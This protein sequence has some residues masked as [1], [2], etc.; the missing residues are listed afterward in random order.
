MYVWVGGRLGGRGYVCV[1]VCVCAV[2]PVDGTT[3]LAA[4]LPLVTCS[5]ALARRG[6]VELG[7]VYDPC[8]SELFAARRGRGA[9]LNGQRIGGGGGG[10]GPPSASLPAKPGRVP[11]QGA[12]AAAGSGDGIEASAAPRKPA[13]ALRDVVFCVGFPP[14]PKAFAQQVALLGGLGPKVRG[15]RSLASCALAC[16]WVGAG[17]LGAYVARDV[18]AWDFA[19]GALVACES[20]G[21]ASDLSTGEPLRPRHR[22]LACS[23]ELTLHATILA[24][25]AE[26]EQPK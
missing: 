2:D 20:G 9:T 24:A 23:V 7:V 21:V 15:V 26:L 12:E 17:R 3:N 6:V 4:G 16:C 1:C 22:D 13:V 25:V 11:G 18:N 10:G 5:I 19:A 14:E 8:R